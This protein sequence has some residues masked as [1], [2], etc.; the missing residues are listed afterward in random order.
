MDRRGFVRTAGG[1]YWPDARAEMVAETT[2]NHVAMLT[3]MRADRHGMPGNAIPA[4]AGFNLRVG[5]NPRYLNGDSLFTVARRQAE[6][7]PVLPATGAGGA[8]AGAAAIGLAE[9]IR[10][11]S[12]ANADQPEA[13]GPSLAEGRPTDLRCCRRSR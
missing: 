8:L 2:P 13:V 12:R 4:R 1:T 7:G 11:T 6:A 9:V 10:R 5:D 3:G